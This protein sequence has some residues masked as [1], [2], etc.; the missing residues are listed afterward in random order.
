MAPGSDRNAAG[1]T[2]TLSLDVSIAA[3]HLVEYIFDGKT[4]VL[5]LKMVTE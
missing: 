4:R 2:R 5:R 3:N 1:S